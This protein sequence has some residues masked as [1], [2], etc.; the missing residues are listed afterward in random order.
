MRMNKEGRNKRI[1]NEGSLLPLIDMVWPAII[2]TAN[3]GPVRI[4]Y[5]CLVLIYASQKR[6]CAASFFPK[7]KYNVCLPVS[8]FMY[9]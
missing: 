5:R 1:E 9:L 4:Q 6:N 8:T 7:Q 2:Y 3:E